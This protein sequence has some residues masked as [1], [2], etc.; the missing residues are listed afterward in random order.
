MLYSQTK[1]FQASE[2]QKSDSGVTKKHMEKAEVI[3]K[4]L[5]TSENIT[6]FSYI[7]LVKIALFEICIIFMSPP[8]I[9]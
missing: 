9:Y 7:S 8:F 6:F 2:V 1:R 5:L 4:L 3:Q